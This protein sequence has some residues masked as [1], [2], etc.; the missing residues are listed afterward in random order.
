MLQ[1]MLIQ[2]IRADMR[3]AVA[4]SHDL[5]GGDN[6]HHFNMLDGDVWGNFLFCFL[7]PNVCIQNLV[8]TSYFSN[9]Y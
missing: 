5:Q 6:S 7:M 2:P 4:E 9:F 3:R 1:I 8:S